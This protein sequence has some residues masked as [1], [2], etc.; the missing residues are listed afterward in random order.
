MP[1]TIGALMIRSVPVQVRRDL[2]AEAKRRGMT[3]AQALALAVELLKEQET[4]S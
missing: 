2:G 4:Q 3:Q 1:S